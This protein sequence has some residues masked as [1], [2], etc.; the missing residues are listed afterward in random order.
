M[1][2]K[3]KLAADHQEGVGPA[4]ISMLGLDLTRVNAASLSNE[5]MQALATR[6]TSNAGRQKFDSFK[7]LADKD[8]SEIRA[9]LLA[10]EQLR[11][12]MP[13]EKKREVFGA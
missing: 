1:S 8:L 11:H 13:E 10:A 9:R 4:P 12:A 2:K 5:E 6:I 3:G 7:P